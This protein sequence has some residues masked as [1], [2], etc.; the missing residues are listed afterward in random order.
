MVLRCERP[1][2]LV[3]LREDERQQQE[4]EPDL[5][6]EGPKVFI[7]CPGCGHRTELRHGGADDRMPAPRS[8]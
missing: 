4:N 3:V 5:E 8:P 1:G 7:T 2:C 6:L